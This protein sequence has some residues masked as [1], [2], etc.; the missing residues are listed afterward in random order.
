MCLKT[1]LRKIICYTLSGELK[2]SPSL[3]RLGAGP[4]NILGRTSASAC[5]VLSGRWTRAA[6]VI[7]VTLISPKGG[8][9]LFL[10]AGDGL[11]LGLQRA[12]SRWST[13]KI[14]RQVVIRC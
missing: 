2:L 11:G 14:I 5:H 10:G 3:P 12:A 8:G 9:D 6:L 13:Q 4:T 7:Q 1:L